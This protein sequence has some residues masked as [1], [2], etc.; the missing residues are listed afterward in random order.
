MGRIE[1]RGVGQV[2]L[3]IAPLTTGGSV[4]PEKQHIL[5][6]DDDVQFV[7]TMETLLQSVGYKVSRA[8]QAERGMSIARETRP[9]LIVLDV[10][11]ARPSELDGITLATRLHRDPDLSGIPV[12]ILSGFTKVA[13]PGYEVRPDPIFM[14]VETFLEKPIT[15]E[16]LLAEI[17]KVLGPRHSMEEALRCPRSN[18]Y[19]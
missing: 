15:P 9:D 14:P 10:M 2:Q 7:D 5:V 6:I 12:I 3:Q 1:P 8:Y 13:D 19:S 17:E 16:E 4:M 18:I 11:F